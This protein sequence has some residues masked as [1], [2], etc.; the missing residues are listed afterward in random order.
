MDAQRKRLEAY[1]SAHSAELVALEL[2]NGTSGKVPPR[3]RPAMARALT[4]IE[5]GD[6]DGILVLKLDRLSRSTRDVLDLV[7]DCRENGWRL[8][9][10]SENLDT[11]T[12][13]G[14]LVVTVLAALAEMER[15]QTIERTKMAL[16]SV[17]RAGRAR[18]RYTP[19]GYRTADGDTEQQKGDR[20]PLVPHAEEQRILERISALRDAGYGARRIARNLNENGRNPRGSKPWTPENVA[21]I[22]RTMER[23]A[24]LVQ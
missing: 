6:A 8:V 10:V 14:R 18:S 20:R 15:E 19:F 3:K 12:A 17:A 4:L 23:R 16:D 7:D 22:V 11:G 2:D 1:C 24:E 5:N 9:S 13:A 21:S